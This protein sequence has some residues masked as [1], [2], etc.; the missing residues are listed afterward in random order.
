[1]PLTPLGA[2]VDVRPLREH[3]PFRRLWLGSTA[4]GIGGQFGAFAVTYYVWDRTRSPAMV[5]LV[6]LAVAA[7]I[8]VVALAGSAFIDQ[9]D[10]RRLAL[11]T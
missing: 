4:S 11:L 3:P 2:L 5:G 10:R 6:G 9:A 7:P 1:M 8:V